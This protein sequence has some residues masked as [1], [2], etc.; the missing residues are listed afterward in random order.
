MIAAGQGRDAQKLFDMIF[1]DIELS[2]R[3]IGVGDL[4]VPKKMK[5]WMKDFNG[6]TQAHAAANADHVEITQRNVFGDDATVSPEF[7]DYINGLFQ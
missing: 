7:Q 6:I 1:H 2:F 5:K 4:A 3:E